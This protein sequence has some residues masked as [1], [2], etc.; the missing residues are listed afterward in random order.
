ML[1]FKN[2]SDPHVHPSSLDSGCGPED[3]LKRELELQSGTI[4]CT[5]H[6]SLEAAY[7]IY[8]LAK[9]NNLTPI[10]GSELYFRDDNCDI[11][12]SFGVDKDADDT[13]KSYLK[14]HHFCIHAMDYPAYEALCKRLSWANLNR[15]EQHGSE[16]K[17]I[18]NW[19]DLQELSHYNLTITNGCLIGMSNRH[20]VFKDRP[21]IGE[22]YFKRMSEWFG[23]KLYVEVFPFECDSHWVDGVFIDLADGT[24]L[25]FY[26]GKQIITDQG[27]FKASELARAFNKKSNKIKRLLGIKN[28]KKIEERNVEIVSVKEVA[29]YF[30][31]ECLGDFTPDPDY[32][33]ATNKFAMH[34]AEK[35]NHKIL[36]SSD[37][38]LAYPEQKLIQDIKLTNGA[39]GH[40]W[41]FANTLTRMSS[42]QA[43]FYVNNKLGVSTPRFEA[44]ID[45]SKQWADRFK[46]FEFNNKPSL[47]AS[48]YPKDTI[49]HLKKLIDEHGRMK[50]KDPIYRER[51][52]SEIELL[53]EIAPQDWLTYFFLNEELRGVYVKNKR[54][55]GPGRG[56]SGGML[57][58]YLLEI[59]DLDPIRHDL[60]KD[61][62]MTPDRIKSGH[63][64][65][66]DSDYPDRS[67]FLDD[68]GEGYL[69]KR[70]GDCFCQISTDVKLRIRSCIKDVHRGLHGS[71]PKDVEEVCSKLPVPPQGIKDHDFIFGY[72][73]GD[74]HH[75]PG[76]LETNGVLKEYIEKYPAEWNI[77][78]QAVSSI[79]KAKSVH[80]SAFVIADRPIGDFIPVTRSGDVVVTQC[81][82]ESVEALGGIKVD[83]LVLNSLKDID[84]CLKLI[85]KDCTDEY[86]YING[87]KTPSFMCVP[88]NNETHYIY[89]LPQLPEV[90]EDIVKT[91]VNTLFQ[92]D[93][94]SAREWLR[95]FDF[96]KPD[97]SWG[98]SCIEDLATF[99][100][101]DRPGP[102]D[103]CIDNKNMLQVYA[104]R[105]KNSE[106]GKGIFA[107]LL[108]KTRSILIYQED[109]SRVYK[110]FTDC[111]NAE[112]E[113]FRSIAAKKKAEKM[114]KAEASFM[115]RAVRKVDKKEAKSV[116]QTMETFA[117]YGFNKSHSYEYAVLAYSTAFLKHFFPLQWWAAV[118]SNA[119]KDDI[120]EKFIQHCS[121]LLLDP[122]INS[123][124]EGFSIDGKNIRAPLSVIEGIGP[125]VHKT[126][127]SLKPYTN[128]FDFGAKMYG[129]PSIKRTVPKPIIHKLILVGAMDSLF[130]KDVTYLQKLQAFNEAYAVARNE[131]KIETLSEDI[132]NM[133]VVRRTMLK[134]NSSVLAKDNLTSVFIQNNP[135]FFSVQDKTSVL[136]KQLGKYKYTLTKP[137]LIKDLSNSEILP[138]NGIRICA[139]AYVSSVRE[140]RFGPNKEKNAAEICLDVDGEKFKFAKWPEWGQDQVQLDPKLENCL[141]LAY[142]A[143]KRSDKPFSIEQF[144]KLEEPIE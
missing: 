73:D 134:K 115:E 24:Q 55:L 75:I 42:A 130:P 124:E 64:P 140:F 96:K 7:K 128:I 77:V 52:A 47:P 125:M 12:K 113:E 44:W 30:K 116:W 41:K 67:L 85:N 20:A 53:H 40:S 50:W 43:Y 28:R 94:P 137:V 131:N 58:A 70:F 126:L 118:L 48:F 114:I 135:K 83:L 120:K 56:S 72:K 39:T 54:M 36:L 101:L 13:Y 122:D 6:G 105:V 74:G 117:K 90:Y 27:E 17:P 88:F 33:L 38:H 62:F 82:A 59:T 133:S 142:L 34:L 2:F 119:S 102:L 26:P 143:K 92:L 86:V 123:S 81:T 49:A 112:A 127:A 60:S 76:I 111:S 108:P 29:D 18:F 19:K 3:F 79:T 138:P 31:N 11:L 107:E 4:T 10:V 99:I 63:W 9:A 136:Y 16:L 69:K 103:A 84:L 87:A 80:A 51:L 5:D 15:A 121:H 129:N 104:S 132:I 97:G 89:D 78:S 66:I 139:I 71:V 23:D 25:R 109:L 37:A 98:I 21:D 1:N 57:I 61:R 22:A 46:G 45:N 14:Y 65:D 32:H 35:Y 91:R 95:E 8:S 110:Y 141:G 68:V 144:V 100:A 93:T 106:Q